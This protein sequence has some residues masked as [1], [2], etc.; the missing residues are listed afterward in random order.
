MP[1]TRP[2]TS[3]I[4]RPLT[5]AVTEGG[6]GGRY[7]RAR[8]SEELDNAAWIK[9]NA[10]VSANAGTDPRGGTTADKLIES[11]A[12]GEHSAYQDLT[13][14]NIRLTFS[15]YVQAAG[16][17]RVVFD[18][19]DLTT[20]NTGATFDLGTSGDVLSAYANGS[21]TNVTAGT[22]YVAPGIWRIWVT[23]TKGAGTTAR[24]KVMLNNGST[25]SY[26][27]D[28]T[29]GVYVWGA[30]ANG[31]ELAT[32]QTV[33]TAD[34]AAASTV[35]NAVPV[36]NNVAAWGDSLTAGAG[37]TTAYPQRLAAAMF[38][39]VYNG[40]VGGET[41]TQIK[42]RMLADAAQHNRWINLLWLGRNNFSD[43]TTVKADI[44][45]CIANLY[46]GNTRYLVLS[47]L[48]S[49]AEGTGSGNLTTILALNA[50]L[51]TLYGSRYVDV[52][53][54]LLTKG[55]GGPTD[56]ADIANGV[57]PTSLRSDAIHLNDTGYQHVADCVGAAMT[58][59]GY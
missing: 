3:A 50:D 48:N 55:D 26:T 11:V 13:V 42:T 39:G 31:G 16:R 22:A 30:Q 49:S 29:S 32:Y 38:R 45:S 36:I 4:T 28:G 59:L 20:G 6:G 58:A 37:G 18:I 41:S 21:W 10:T 8:Y 52:R 14:G 27:G 1:I 25:T 56:N 34:T 40:G 44:A 24:H 47:V 15:R 7:N 2:I 57:I 51:A 19:S 33:T 12:A 5:S 9:N 53:A 17:S 23:A 46:T 35:W 54:Y 43:P